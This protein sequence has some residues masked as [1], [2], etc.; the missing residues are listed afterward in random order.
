[1]RFANRSRID[2]IENGSPHARFAVCEESGR[3][4][5]V[6]HYAVAYDW[7]KAAKVAGRNG[8]PDWERW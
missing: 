4:W 6:M 5:S 7:E 1:M 3:S 8:R 2:E